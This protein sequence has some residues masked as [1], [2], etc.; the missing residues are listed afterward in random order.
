MAVS[1]GKSRPLAPALVVLFTLV[2]TP[3]ARA[4][5]PAP[6]RAVYTGLPASA[7]AASRVAGLLAL[8]SPPVALDDSPVHLEAA[9]GTDPFPVF[10]AS[11]TACATGPRDAASYQQ[12]LDALY[13]ATLLAL[14]VEPLIRRTVAM[15]ACLTEPVDPASLA[16]ADFVEAV[17]AF[18]DGDEEAARAAFRRVF[19]IDPHHPWDEEFPPDAQILFAQVATD[20][21]RAERGSLTVIA[22]PGDRVWIDGRSVG[23]GTARAD[24]PAGRH[25]VQVVPGDGGPTQT[26]SLTTTP[27]AAVAV[28]PGTATRDDLSPDEGAGLA[29]ALSPRAEEGP[30]YL[31]ALSGAEVLVWRAAVDGD[32]VDRVSPPAAARAVVAGLVNLTPE[33]IRARR[34]A[35]GVL[36]GS[37]AGLAVAGTLLAVLSRR[38]AETLR[39]GVES[40]E[41][42]PFPCEGDPQPEEYE[43]YRS[44]RSAGDRMGLGLALLGA[45][46]GLMV[47]SIP[48]GSVGGGRGH[49]IQV[50]GYLAPG[51]NTA[52]AIGRAEPP[53]LTVGVGLQ[54]RPAEDRP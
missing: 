50:G 54:I 1:R 17:L 7:D 38:E 30:V 19:A 52:A 15:Q 4:D 14:D 35:A 51:P 8:L 23:A 42:G 36:L 33:R 49:R 45:G 5:E 32:G 40:G 47:A 6:A 2:V 48:V 21:V 41:L 9:L 3:A 10:G 44:W 25:L 22:G 31:V 46:G 43:L 24:L 18:A 16:R 27:D 11:G 12:E 13:R 26:L 28:G 29:Q 37:G 39:A 34:T 53:P 20:V